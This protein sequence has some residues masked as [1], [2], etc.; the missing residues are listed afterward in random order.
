MLPMS[1][2]RV[3]VGSGFFANFSVKFQCLMVKVTRTMETGRVKR[4]DVK[5]LSALQKTL[6]SEEG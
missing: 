5:F 4:V 6:I 3:V 2:T 1:A